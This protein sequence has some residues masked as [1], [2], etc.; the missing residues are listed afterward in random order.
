M[1]HIRSFNEDLK[2]PYSG[3]RGE[4]IPQSQEPK[5]I[6]LAGPDVFRKNALSRLN[7]LREF[8]K[9]YG[10]EG[11]MP[12]D[13][14]INIE[15]K[16]MHTQKHSGL[17]FLANVN[18]IDECDVIIANI[19]PFRGPSVDDGT[20]WEIGYG[21]A[22]GKKIW[23]YSQFSDLSLKEITDMMFDM[24]R[25]KKF[26]MYEM[27]GNPVNLMIADSIKSSGG[28]IF[29]TFEECLVDLNKK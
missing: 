19:E 3:I 5:K 1:K 17:I 23:G 9:R 10:H 20:A 11:L 25:Q 6:Y 15:E 22:K 26:P 13:N 4:S 27:M 29:A 2:I 12:L 18:L 24:S 28:K 21:Y 14:T 8:A 16:D 7:R